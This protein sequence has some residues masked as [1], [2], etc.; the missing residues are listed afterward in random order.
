LRWQCLGKKSKIANSLGRDTN[1]QY[2]EVISG[3]RR[4]FAD[5]LADYGASWRVLRVTSVADQLFIKAQRIRT[6]QETG[7]NKIGEG[8]EPE[9]LGLLNYG[10]IA[11]IQIEKGFTD[12]ADISVEEGMAL[13]DGF[14]A[15]AKALMEKKNHDY[16]E[17]WREMRVG[18]MADMIMV[19][20]LRIK[21]IEDNDGATL[22]SE[23]VASNFYDII[24]Y[25][26][27]AL[28]KFSEQ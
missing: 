22:I 26:I 2:D 10:I 11:L 28:I 14:V 9:F 20:I 18:S 21:Q 19:K 13:Y 1:K 6:L 16:G 17:A 27:F 24:N 3:A 8:I 5:K 25:S 4:V 15:K 7:V 12:S 23:G